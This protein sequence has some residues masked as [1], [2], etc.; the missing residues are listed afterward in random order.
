MSRPPRQREQSEG[1]DI[2]KVSR[3]ASAFYAGRRMGT[4]LSSARWLDRALGY[5]PTAQ[6]TPTGVEIV[7]HE[8]LR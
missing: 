3:V 5:G 7:E 6:T 8:A 1:A 2:W 4:A